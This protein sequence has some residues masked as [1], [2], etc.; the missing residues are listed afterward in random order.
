MKSLLFMLGL[1][2]ACDPP[3]ARIE[4]RDYQPDHIEIVL[5]GDSPVPLADVFECYA[6]DE[7]EVSLIYHDNFIDGDDTMITSFQIT[8]TAHQDRALCVR[9]AL[10]GLGG[11][12]TP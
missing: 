5:K 8:T 10:L 2:V 4:P 7:R 1:C 3:T 12:V 9:K 6:S 11:E